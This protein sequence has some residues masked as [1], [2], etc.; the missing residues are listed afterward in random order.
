MKK[1]HQKNKKNNVLQRFDTNFNTGLTFQ[2][3]K[4][5][6]NENLTN[7]VS[8]KNSKSYLNIICSNTF[9]YFNL[10]WAIIIFA[11]I[12]VGSFNNLL[13]SLII[14]AN[15]LIAIIQECKAKRTVDKL[16]LVTAPK[17][18]VVRGGEIQ[19]VQSEAL[20]LDDIVILE[21]G[22]QIPAD[23]VLVNGMV[24]VNESLLTGESNAIKKTVGANL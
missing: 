13:F 8:N 12:Y 14:I 4:M 5:R 2:Q 11:Y 3:V 16:S 20:V 7:K 23:C 24:E 10:I 19:T 6:Q 18:Q 22:N 15:T 9:T 17:V 1:T 21:T